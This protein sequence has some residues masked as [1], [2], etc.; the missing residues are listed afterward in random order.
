[1]P[2]CWVGPFCRCVGRT[3]LSVGDTIVYKPTYPQN[4]EL[5]GFHPLYFEEAHFP[6][7][8]TDDRKEHAKVGQGRGYSPIAPPLYPPLN[9]TVHVQCSLTTGTMSSPIS[10]GDPVTT[11]V[12]ILRN[13][14]NHLAKMPQLIKH[15]LAKWRSS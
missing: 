7:F 11:T 5:L 14:M 13:P 9:Q 4:T 2:R 15:R 6:L 8:H 10:N 12:G 3:G 1:M